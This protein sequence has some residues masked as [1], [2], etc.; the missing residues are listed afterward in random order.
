MKRYIV[1]MLVF[2]GCGLCFF[3]ACTSK[4]SEQPLIVIKNP[5]PIKLGD[6]FLLHAN[7]GKYYLYGTS[8]KDGFECFSS[9]DLQNW[10][11][12]G[13]VYK[14]GQD[15]QWN[16][17]CFWAPEVYERNGKY[18]LFYSANVNDSINVN[19]EK[20][21][22]N[23][24]V[25]VSNSPMGPFEDL[26]NRPIF[27]PKF[28]IIDANVYFDDQTGKCYLYFSR[29]CYQHPVNSELAIQMKKENHTYQIIE[30]NKDE[31]QESWI[32]GV[33][34]K[35][36]FSG[37]IGPPQLLLQPPTKMNDKQAEWESRSVLYGEVNR[38]WTEGPFV[39]KVEDT[40]YM[41]YSANFYKGPYYAV[42]YATSKKPLGP[43]YKA[44]NNPIL[45]KNTDKGGNI[46][47]TGHNMIINI[48]GQLYIV[49]HA[50]TTD[51]TQHRVVMIDTLTIKNEQ[52]LNI[53]N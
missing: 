12:C 35:S 3:A 14:G 24:G 50:Y 40:Y 48:D 33:E 41:M 43:F 36:D 42:G 23:I 53:K 4:Q 34:L 29:C 20:E 6:P 25:A 26:Y 15:G 46:T 22:F 49:Y 17:N 21:S 5:L 37:V 18:Y 2:M 32:Y 16:K 11:S 52:I 51:D 31:I 45:Q 8:L 9:K 39:F 27:T 1:L 44:Y 38:R 19:Q 47:G 10:D 7:D 13:Q 30:G 28:P